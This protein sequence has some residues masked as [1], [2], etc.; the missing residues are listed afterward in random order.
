MVSIRDL[1]TV[2]KMIH[3]IS[4]WEFHTRRAVFICQANFENDACC[5]PFGIR[6]PCLKRRDLFFIRDIYLVS[7]TTHS[8]FH[9][10]TR[11]PACHFHVRNPFW[12]RRSVSFIRDPEPVLKTIHSVYHSWLRR[13]RS[14]LGI[15]NPLKFSIRDLEYVLK[16]IQSVS[17]SGLWRGLFSFGIWSPLAK[18]YIRFPIWN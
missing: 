7:R 16:M 14:S 17:H 15:W 3:L 9:S 10:E 12:K 18:W 6:S 13:G 5:F 11:V 1:E 2:S 4:H 8:V